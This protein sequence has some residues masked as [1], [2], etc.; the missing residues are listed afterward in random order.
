MNTI[1]QNSVTTL[2]ACVS[3]LARR[4]GRR[5][6]A[7]LAG[8]AVLV[9]LSGAF[10][11]PAHAADA[12][13]AV[14]R[15]P[16]AEIIPEQF[17]RRWDA[18]TL[19]FDSAVGP[20]KGGPENQP[21]KFVT[22][23]PAHPGAYVW[24]NARTLQFRPAEPWPPLTRF[25]WKLAGRAHVL[26][27]LMEAPTQTI[28]EHNSEGLNA[29]EAI[30]L[31]FS[32]PVA[33][34]ALARMLT[35]ELRPLPGLDAKQSRWLDRNHFTIKTIERANRS[36]PANYVVS[37]RE[38]IALGHK[39][40]VHLR[41][42]LEHRAETL[43]DIV[44]STA[45]PFRAVSVGC[46]QQRLPI[47]PAGV[48][49][50]REQAIACGADARHIEVEFSGE[51]KP[52]GAIEARNFVRI[53]PSV[54]NLEFN[55]GG[56][57]LSIAGRFNA[58]TLYR[59]SLMPLPLSDRHGRPLQMDAPSEVFVY[60][61]NKPSFLNWQTH[62]GI[63][64][65]FGPQMLPVAGRGFDAVDLRVYA[66]DPRDRSFWPFPDNPVTVDESARPPGPGEEP[67]P[68]TDPQS[69]VTASELAQHIAALGSPAISSI[70]RLPLKRESAAASFG[71]DLAPHLSALA[72]KNAPGTYLVGLRRID[73]SKER[74]WVRVQVTDLS[75][76]TVEEAGVVKFF[77]TSLATGEPVAGAKIAV[78][79]SHS[80][81]GKSTWQTFVSGSTDRQGLFAWNAP[82]DQ[83]AHRQVRRIVVQYDR[84]VLTL[85]PTRPPDR[86]AD[87]HWSAAGGTWLQWTQHR[88]DVRFP[89]P[90]EL[91]HLFSE[92]PV[93]RPDEPVHLKGYLRTRHQGALRIDRRG[94][95]LVVSGPGDAS[96]RYPL[97][98]TAAGSFY[99]LFKEET[100]ATGNY[101][102][103][104]EDKHG[105]RCGQV[106]FVKEAYRVPAF[107]I[108]LHA[109]E[110][111]PLDRPFDIRL[112]A[113][114][115]AGG[116]VAQRPVRWRV[117]QFPYTWTPA[118]R[119]GYFYSSDGR[120]SGHARFDATPVTDR[121]GVTDD[122]GAATIS[123]NPANETSAQPRSY[124]VEATVTGADDQTVSSTRR[125][126]A[127]PAVVLGLKIP[128]FIARA[129][130]VEPEVIALSATGE[131]LA[132][133]KIKLRLLKR[134]WH[135]HLR[136]ADFSQGDAK[137]VTEV[138]DKPV[139]ERNIE[140][141]TKPTTLKLPVTSAGVYIVE[142]E[143]QDRLGRAQVVSVDFYA[144]GN[145]PVTWSRPPT[146][147]FNVTVDRKSYKPGDTA[148][149]VLESPFQNGRALAIVE[150][151]AGNRYEW[152]TVRNGAADFSLPIQA[153]F[154]PRV[155]VHF[156]LMRGR[157][158]N[159][160]ATAGGKMDLGKP[161]TVAA[162]AW[163]NVE[164]VEHQVTVALKYNA[165]ALPGEKLPVKIQLSDHRGKPLAGEVTL[166]LVDQ[167]VLALGK[168]QRLDPIP[169]F[170]TQVRSHLSIVDTRNLAVGWLPFQEQPGGDDM[171]VAKAMAPMQSLLDKVSVRR[172]FKTVP[173]FNPAIA[174][175][176]DGSAT[177]EVA[178]PDNL[179]N[180]KIR[181][182]AISNADRFGVGVGEVAVRLPVLVQPA[183]PRFVR[184]GDRFTGTAIA[185]VVEGKGGAAVAEA[186]VE[187]GTVAGTGRKEF[188]L[189]EKR[190][191]R[192]EY[193]VSVPTPVYNDQGQPVS[194]RLRFTLGIERSADRAKDAFQVT[195]PIRPDRARVRVRSLHELAPGEKV[196]LPAVTEA[197]RSGTFKQQLLLSNQPALIRMAAGLSFLM[198]YPYG[199]TEQRLSRARAYL[200]LK[201]F[202]DV[203]QQ[204]GG[205]E[206]LERVVNEALQWSAKAVDANGLAAYWPGAHG[207][208]SL[209]AWVVEF[210]VEARNAG[211]TIDEA[212]LA[213][214]VATLKQALRS[215]YSRFI[216]GEAY[217]E[218]VMALRALAAAGAMDRAY[219]AELARRVQYL[220]LES[221]AQVSYLLADTGA[222]AAGTVKSLDQQLW[223]GVVLRLHQG[224]TIYG[225]L[226]DK[227]PVRNGLILPSETRTLS[228]V[229][230]T[231]AKNEKDDPRV[232]TLINAL[233]GLGQ[234]DGWGS[235]NANAAAMLALSEFMEAQTDGAEHTATVT[236]GAKPRPV[237]IGGKTPMAALTLTKPAAV[238]IAAA[239]GART[240]VRSEISYVPAADGGSVKPM[241]KGFVVT[242]EL[243]K[244]DAGAR[245]AQRIALD[246]GG[247]RVTFA[248]GDVIEDHVEVVNPAD[249]NYI[250]VV[251]P[252][253]AGVEP[254]NP[255]LATAEAAAT[256]S[257]NLSLA[258]TYVAY[259]DDQ[260]AFYYDALPK[261]TYQFYFRTRATVAGD[262]AQPP[263]RA[264]MMYDEAVFG[265]SA[266]AR[267]GVEPA[268]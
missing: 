163:L 87:N 201:K 165:K 109:P 17:L 154:T 233:V 34:S 159:A 219:A 148:H 241:A 185:R 124:V 5:V 214:L 153:G 76:S 139:L 91:C 246:D 20:E 31:T 254:M 6:P 152:I 29:V 239:T 225:G 97:K 61:S 208:V 119:E 245:P 135:S 160:T 198:H 176:A 102:A 149:V 103:H 82:G 63:I 194:E 48:R 38:P 74:V 259:L 114:Y 94:G 41:L 226:Q 234:G 88:L 204:E 161:A 141:D 62:R 73:D 206:E 18:V 125:I 232:Q 253:A 255:R 187:G 65:R 43:R 157:N 257:G 178:L 26:P 174:V 99:H 1:K 105:R 57:T 181:A 170:I 250:A 134:E 151:P 122:E 12:P 197:V 71:L 68:F 55:S 237:R 101:T 79:G 44:F 230:R 117:S 189:N 138:V 252:L 164:P 129:R 35:I 228:E 130:E 81:A 52:I 217:T 177:I 229:A 96:W 200:A 66:L 140:T 191:E 21:Q 266:G 42:S 215:D 210:M 13:V 202:R 53:T 220:G 46:P 28:P 3:Q 56:K 4:L 146:R 116:Q 110:Q 145:E 235:T 59:V 265:H 261:G 150:A 195:L 224:Q 199:C 39:A 243:L 236:V 173:Y 186:R 67:A 156:V 248:I 143:T 104:F 262:F 23:T 142:L 137:Y 95:E 89:Q 147:V 32:E 249:R 75:L 11:T 242:R 212:L 180:F 37:L 77:V 155:P 54:E 51:T 231:L 192:V 93:Y 111:V 268:P 209:T 64:E 45:E 175:G 213:N 171:Y 100:A 132:G 183:L 258:P 107:E 190:A 169:D 19:F 127:L 123:L 2:N 33:A 144:A 15:S 166:W 106:S 60:F 118:Q 126:L 158:K 179:T 223:N 98:P 85:D 128:R 47:A 222:A 167:A 9:S 184:A 14:A 251:V 72:G 267:V 205:E 247:K 131:L 256:P 115:Y 22:L 203:L 80:A 172:N 162:T 113:K 16:G 108:A 36:D 8:L 263:A 112:T 227:T 196:E 70:V 168:E 136:A 260:V 84:D 90:E 240:L 133:Q 7:Q 69:Y 211:F 182:K 27:T 120:F 264:E 188:V 221:L 50:T 40:F 78:E 83:R 218:R 193:Q 86:Y 121:S 238:G 244:I 207:Y 216:T 25:N 24:L 92:R 58:D 49:Y 10:F 30:T